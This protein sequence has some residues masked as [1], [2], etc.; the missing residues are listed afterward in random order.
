MKKYI[1]AVV[2]VILITELGSYAFSNSEK[3]SQ[4]AVTQEIIALEKASF[5]AWQRKDKKFYADYWADDFTEFLPQSPTLTANPKQ[6]L[7]P[8]L[9][10]SF[11]DWTLTD[12]QMTDP[13]V[14][15]YGN[16]AVLTY[17]ESVQG[18]YKGEA[19][20]YTGKV[21]MVYVKRDGKWKGVHYHE[22]QNP[23][24]KS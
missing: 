12:L 10:Q 8:N 5:A 19:T 7:L 20:K 2:L 11:N 4:Q 3:T 17:E 16:V 13:R 15:L 6:T 9:E 1:V 24:I 21:T 18:S 23:S 14:Q 22:S